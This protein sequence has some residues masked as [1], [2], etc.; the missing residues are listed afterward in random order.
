[1]EVRKLKNHFIRKTVLKIVGVHQ[2]LDKIFT[3]WLPKC[4]LILY[5]WILLVKASSWEEFWVERRRRMVRIEN[6]ATNYSL[7]NLRVP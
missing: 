7:F 3:F 4:A 5:S 1:M 6:E 2:T